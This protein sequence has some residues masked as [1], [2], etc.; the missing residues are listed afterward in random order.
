M[1]DADAGSA[2][3]SSAADAGPVAEPLTEENAGK[4]R[5]FPHLPGYTFEYMRSLP[6]PFIVQWGK[7][8]TTLRA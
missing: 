8:A 2:A 6:A 4:T 5:Y 7:K 3:A 1:A